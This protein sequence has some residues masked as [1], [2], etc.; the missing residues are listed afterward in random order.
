MSLR[1]LS[2]ELGLAIRAPNGALKAEILYSDSAPSASAEQNAAPLSSLLLRNDSPK[3]YQK[4]FTNNNPADWVELG[5][6][7][8]ADLSWRTETIRVATNDTV[9]AGTVDP[10]GF[11][12][13]ESG[14]DGNSFAVGQYLL[15]DA[16][17]SPALFRVDVINSAT[18]IEVSAASIP[19][20]SNNAMVVQVYLPDSPAEQEQGAILYL[21]ATGAPVIKL[22]DQNWNF[23]DGIG[24]AAGYTAGSGG[25]T[26]TSSD[27]VQ[28][29]LQ[30][31][32]GNIRYYLKG[33]SFTGI[34]ETFQDIEVV[35]VSLYNFAKF[36]IEVFDATTPANRKAVEVTVLH[37]GSSDPVWTVTNVLTLGAGVS[38]LLITPYIETTNFHIEVDLSGSGITNGTIRSR[39]LEVKSAP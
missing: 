6:V 12:D 34:N 26:V 39:R 28:S 2:A 33:T 4:R 19:L 8:F 30:K 37:D 15:G 5:N 22:G 27:S 29:A 36:L 32:D 20:A 31:L 38:P 13:N 10:T 18:D 11:S 7:S 23:A 25:E 1:K 21:P 24:L 14:I 35:D 3:I 17:G 16:N 9:V